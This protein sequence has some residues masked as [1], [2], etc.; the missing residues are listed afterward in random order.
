[1][2]LANTALTDLPS[3]VPSVSGRP[4]HDLHRLRVPDDI[5]Q[6]IR[7]QQ[8]GHQLAPGCLRPAVGP[9]HAGHLAPGRGQD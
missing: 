2:G 5:S 4:R 1:M 3:H 9:P 6:E 7:V 8:R